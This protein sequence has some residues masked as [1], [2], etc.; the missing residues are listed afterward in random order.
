MT[1]TIRVV[2]Y[3]LGPIGCATARL[4]VEREG[5]ELVGGIDIA[6]AKAGRD[7]GTV[8]GLPHELGIPVDSQLVNCLRRT[9]ADVVVH[10]T[11]SYFDLFKEQIIEIVGL[12]LDVVSTSEE[13]VF[14]WLSHEPEAT[15]IDKRAREA[16]K[17][18]LGTGVNPGF[19]MDS[20]PLYL[21]GICH[22]VDRID[23]K[24]VINASLRRGPFQLKIGAGLSVA[25]FEKRMATGRM[26]HVGL[27]ESIDMVFHRLGKHLTA[28]E[29][30][31]EPL[32]ADRTITTDFVTVAP[33]LVRGLKQTARAYASGDEFM[34]LT[35]IAA[36]EAEGEGDTIK[37]AGRPNLEVE[38]YGTN[39]DLATTAIAA[40]AI[41]RVKAAAPGLITMDDMPMVTVW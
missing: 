30:D 19:V 26:G 28:Y 39:G 12:G 21:T 40:N 3:G 7:L 34:T 20:L 35:F 10:T 14:P 33:G 23:V 6:P 13:L 4:I 16:G 24:R 5:L 17:T 37:I 32:I 41:R 25:E 31:L 29:S 38:L 15:E 2:Q 36:L 1:D 27:P 11:N 9:P 22:H 18:V 8:I